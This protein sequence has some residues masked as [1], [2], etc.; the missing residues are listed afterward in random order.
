MTVD[1]A[2]TAVAGPAQAVE[3]TSPAGATVTL[4]GTGTDPDPGDTLS[5]RWTDG[6]LVLGTTPSI[7]LTVPLGIYVFTLRV[8]D[9][10]GAFAEAT[11][12][13][14]VEDT[15][16]PVLTLPGDLT[17]GATSPAGAIATFTASALDAVD[18]PV[19][20][21]CAPAS[22]SSFPIGTT[23]VTCTATDASGNAASGSFTVTVA[24]ATRRS[25][26]GIW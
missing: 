12:A 26:G 9:S 14:T 18:G 10:H 23:T 8:T 25:C 11:V 3:A 21:V 4:T 7:T 24:V 5:Y 17:I 19:A 1:R 20:V 22:G 16:G 15:R 2:P 13:V 6:G